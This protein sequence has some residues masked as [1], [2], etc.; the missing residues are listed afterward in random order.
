MKTENWGINQHK[1]LLVALLLAAAVLAVYWSVQ[2]FDFIEFDDNAYISENRHIMDGFTCEAVTWALKDIHTGYWHP[3]TWM[4]H[5]L[6]YKLFRMNAG[7]HHW[8]SVLL[9]LANTILLFFIF[10]RMTAALWK[11]A[12]V[13]ALFAIHPMHVESV[14]WV[15]ERKD[16]LSTFFLFLTIGCYIYY[17]QKRNILR[18]FMMFSCFLLSLLSKPMVVTLPFALLLLDYW[19]L[20]RFTWDSFLWEKVRPLIREK[21]P[22]I[23]LSVFVSGITL[24]TAAQNSNMASLDKLPLTTRAVNAML[25]YGRYMDKSI[26]PVDM[27]I[28]YPYSSDYSW[29]SVGGAILTIIIVSVLSISY[30]KRFP[31]LIIGWLWFLGIMF[32]VIGLV[33]AGAQGMADRYTYVSY[34][35]LFIMIAWGV[36]DLTASIRF[37]KSLL[38]VTAGVVL[39]VLLLLSWV[40]VRYWE[41]TDTLF[42]HTI[43]VTGRNFLAET[44]LATYLIKKGKY[45]EAQARLYKARDINPTYDRIYSSLGV[46]LV[47]QKRYEEA[48]EQYKKALAINAN[49][50]DAHFNIGAVYAMLG[51]IDDAVREFRLTIA[52][53]PDHLEGRRNLGTILSK[54]GKIDEAVGHYQEVLKLKPNDADTLNDLGIAMAHNGNFE[55]AEKYFLAALR[56]NP[57]DSVVHMNIGI[58]LISQNRVPDAIIRFEEAL[59]LDPANETARHHLS[60]SVRRLP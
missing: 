45:E 60:V 25:S 4:S 16:V 17:L 33:Q 43:E 40:Q 20:K 26:Y 30:V 35:G 19:P 32:P 58:T 59:R 11:S 47:H 15:A 48:L 44:T 5:V 12:F 50:P 57:K 23:L 34:I 56:I 27:A 1:E 46:T 37:R 18:Y 52:L 41:N 2:D 53:Q 9:H 49:N 31:Y 21:I 8:T 39:S 24:A 42:R 55:E 51:R 54:Q 10:Y 36:P 14:A 29:V 6:D 28:F 22:L 13:A 7:G 3:L 38:S